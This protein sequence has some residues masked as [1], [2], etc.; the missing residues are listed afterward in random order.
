MAMITSIRAPMPVAETLSAAAE[1]RRPGLVST[2][3]S[4]PVAETALLQAV[5]Q[6]PA[7]AGT[8]DARLLD[9]RMT[10]DTSAAAAAAAAREAYIR[11]SIAAGISPLPL[12]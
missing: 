4:A 1:P 9:A 2:G 3:A 8:A 10:L 6:I 12:P 5:Q 7:K 11:A